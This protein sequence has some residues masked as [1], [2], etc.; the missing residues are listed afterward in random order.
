MPQG[1]RPPINH[2]N[3][4]KEIPSMKN[5]LRYLV[6]PAIAL[7]A[8]CGGEFRGTAPQA[9]FGYDS[10]L[11]AMSTYV[12][13]NP[14]S[15]A[16]LLQAVLASDAARVDV[17]LGQNACPNARD[18]TGITA[19]MNA[20]KLGSA[21][22]VKSLVAKGAD[23]HAQIENGPSVIGLL[24]ELSDAAVKAEI[25]NLIYAVTDAKGAYAFPSFKLNIASVFQNRCAKCHND[26]SSLVDYSVY[27][28]AFKRQEKV[29]NRVVTRRDMPTRNVTHMTDAEFELTAKWV[30]SGAAE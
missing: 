21:S 17:L 16:D 15:D 27:A 25:G 23:F 8:G 5:R 10:N 24:N 7:F 3:F 13:C 26:S 22:I 20:V 30:L 29:F 1:L 9:M 6:W 2:P 18:A 19:L 11:L 4:M 14:A 28:N 12:A